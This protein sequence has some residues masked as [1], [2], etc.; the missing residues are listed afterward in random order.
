MNTYRPLLGLPLLIAAACH[1]ATTPEHPTSAGLQDGSAKVNALMT[2]EQPALQRREVALADGSVRL[3]VES[4]AAPTLTRDGDTVALTVPLG[5][6]EPLRCQIESEIDMAATLRKVYTAL[7]RFP[8]REIVSS[9]AGE[10][11]G[12]AFVALSAVYLVEEQKAFGQLKLFAAHRGLDSG[13]F[14]MHDE[15]GYTATTRRVVASI[16]QTLKVKLKERRPAPICRQVIAT[17][18][19]G[20]RIGATEV[21]VS[22]LPNG[23]IH[24][25]ESSSSLFIRTPLEFEGIDDYSAVNSRNGIIENAAYTKANGS[26]GLEFRIELKRDKGSSYHASGTYH[27]QKVDARFAAPNLFS[28]DR[29]AELVRTKLLPTKSGQLALIGYSPGSDPARISHT[30][31]RGLGDGTYEISAGDDAKM[32]VDFDERGEPK[33]AKLKVATQEVQMERVFSEGRCP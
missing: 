7:E 9:D 14:C 21:R 10:L 27:D 28:S 26:G 23:M 19:G 17:T 18:I 2:R 32:M 5:T 3:S 6:G 30:V 29:E 13:F 22:K 31:I 24:R 33:K 20:R 12:A 8:K 16:A 1:P 15:P 4:A 11:G 25:F